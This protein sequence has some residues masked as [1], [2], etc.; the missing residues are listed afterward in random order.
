MILFGVGG[1][2][3]NDVVLGEEVFEGGGAGDP[4]FLEDGVGDAGGESGK[5]DIEG[6]EEGDHFL[7]DGAEAVEAEA[8][9]EEALGDGFHAVLPP[10]VSVHGDVP[11]SG[12]AHGGK[13]EEEAAFGNG[14]ADGVPPVGDEEAIFDERAGDKFFDAAGEVSD[15]AELA[16]TADGQV[17]WQG[18][19]APSA[20]E[21][22][23]LMLMEKRWP[24]RGIG[25][26]E[27]Q[28]ELIQGEAVELGLDGRGKKVFLLN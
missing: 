21:G 4:E 3:D 10:R 24:R 26:G 5:G 14:A 9:A 6:A 23:G 19:A 16:G 27:R 22:F 18:R 2:F 20:E 7:G 15:V 8:A 1:E 13:N 11:V 28:G 17:G 25:E 12:A